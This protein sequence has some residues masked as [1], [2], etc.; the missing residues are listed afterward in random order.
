MPVRA[1]IEITEEDATRYDAAKEKAA[2]YD[3]AQFIFKIL[4]NSAYGSL[5]N[6]FFRF[7]SRQM[8][9]SVTCIGR[10]ILKHQCAEVNRLL[11]GEYRYDG[12][13]VIY[14]DY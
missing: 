14:A 11:T 5:I 8:G 6:K 3:R 2:Y 7:Y 9:E 13:A 12:E 4:L 1:G 10:L